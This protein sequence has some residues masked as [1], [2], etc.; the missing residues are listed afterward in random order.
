MTVQELISKGKNAIR[1]NQKLADVFRE[2]FQE[3][4]GRSANFCCSFSDFNKLK[5]IINTQNRE[6]M[7]SEV[8][9]YEVKYKSNDIL[10]YRKD[11]RT[12]RR[13]VRDLTDDFIEEFLENHSEKHY[14]N[15]GRFIV[16][17]EPQDES[18]NAPQGESQEQ[19]EDSQD[20]PQN[21]PEGE[22][23]VIPVNE[24]LSEVNVEA[25]EYKTL[26][27]MVLELAKQNKNELPDQKKQTLI[28]YWNSIHNER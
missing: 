7:Q 25:M 11:G 23:E 26:K 18:K 16:E 21:E 24:D 27:S 2:F 9:N 20:E 22:I 8:K 12:Y 4:F 15:V 19:N 28:D 5:N 17:I 3:Y 10:A 13:Y 1:N 6:I 14:P